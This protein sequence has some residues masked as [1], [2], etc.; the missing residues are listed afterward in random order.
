MLNKISF[1]FFLIR[2]GFCPVT[3]C[4]ILFNKNKS[5]E[6][7]QGQFRNRIEKLRVFYARSTNCL[8]KIIEFFKIRDKISVCSHLIF[9]FLFFYWNNNVRDFFFFFLLLYLKKFR[10][11]PPNLKSTHD[12]EKGWNSPSKYLHKVT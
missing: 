3:L 4:F 1:F 6:Q 10:Q 11:P 12:I 8:K 9:S 2:L 7:Q 5:Y